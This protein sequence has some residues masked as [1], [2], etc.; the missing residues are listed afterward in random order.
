MIVQTPQR[1]VM[2]N[3]RQRISPACGCPNRPRT[4]RQEFRFVE[5][6]R[7]ATAESRFRNFLPSDLRYTRASGCIS[8]A[9]GDLMAFC[10]SC[11]ATLNP[12]TRFCNKCGAAS[13]P[14]LRRASAC[15]SA[16]PPRPSRATPGRRQQRPQNHPHRHRRDRPSSVSSAWRLVGHRRL[17]HRQENVACARNGDNVKVETPFGTVESTKDPEKAAKDLGVDIY[18]GAEVQQERRSLRHLW[19]HPHRQRIL[20][21]HR[22]RRQGLRFYKAKFPNAIVRTS[23]ENHCTIV[24]SATT[25]VITINIEPNGDGSR[26]RSPSVIKQMTVLR[27]RSISAHAR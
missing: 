8:L 14:T 26:F 25:N 1:R 23:D 7:S 2:S 18:P 9:R 17:P 4:A 3:V 6:L 27:M 22:F 10:N 15:H 16:A 24:S 13:L 12:G 11:G 21:Q 19:Q 5:R 20:H